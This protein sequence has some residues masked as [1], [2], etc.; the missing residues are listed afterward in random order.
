MFMKKFVRRC[1]SGDVRRGVHMRVWGGKSVGVVVVVVGL[2]VY[3][4][5]RGTEIVCCFF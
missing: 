4:L 2:G 5:T 1:E 3:T